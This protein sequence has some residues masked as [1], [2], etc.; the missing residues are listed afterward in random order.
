MTPISKICRHDTATVMYAGINCPLCAL[1][2]IT[3]SQLAELSEYRRL[4]SAVFQAVTPAEKSTL[5]TPV[6][7]DGSKIAC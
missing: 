2:T 5:L 3:K 7:A 4:E 6:N 1:L